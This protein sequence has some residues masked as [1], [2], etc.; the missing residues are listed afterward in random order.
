MGHTSR[1]FPFVSLTTASTAI[2]AFV[3][4][5][6]KDVTGVER[7]VERNARDSI[8]NVLYMMEVAQRLAAHLYYPGC[9]SL[10][11]KR[12]AADSPADWVRPGS[13]RAAY[14]KRRWTERDDRVLLELDNP[15]TAAEALDR[16]ARSCS[17]RLWRLRTGQVATPSGR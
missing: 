11:R 16:T 3:C 5:Y 14:T 6:A 8:Y 2:G 1:G 7:N 15:R 10:E 9:L 4:H 12:T 17:M 13:M